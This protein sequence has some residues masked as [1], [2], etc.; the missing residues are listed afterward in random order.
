MTATERMM[1]RR[2]Q[3]TW[4]TA[5]AGTVAS[6]ATGF[7]LM[8]AVV[9][10]TYVVLS[11]GRAGWHCPSR[12]EFVRASALALTAAVAGLVRADLLWCLAFLAA[13]G[14]AALAAAAVTEADHAGAAEGAAEGVSEQ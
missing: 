2:A 3:T 14:V 10:A 1:R 5:A 9:I 13:A 4:A 7:Y 6:L 12:M 8:A 11:G